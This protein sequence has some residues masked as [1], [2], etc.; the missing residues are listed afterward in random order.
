[1]SG[2][3][4]I[5]SGSHSELPLIHAARRL[6]F[7][8]TT[9]GNR[10]DHPGH[11]ISDAYLP[12]DFSCPIQMLEVAKNSGCDFIVS[13]AN[14][15]A[16][17]SSCEVA[18]TLGYTGF[19]QPTVAYSLHHKHL[20]KPL[21]ASL[22]IP[23]TKFVSIGQ[24][25]L[26]IRC[27]EGLAFPL[28]VKP[29]DLTGGKGITVVND[30]ASLIT[31][32]A[33]ARSLSKSPYVVIE[34]YFDGTLHS[35]STIIRHGKVIFEYSD[36]EFCSPS[37]YLVSTSTSQAK[38]TQEVLAE[39]KIHTEKLAVKLGLIDG[40]LHCQ[41]LYQNR[42]FVIL[43]YTRRCSGDLYSEVVEAVTGIRH[44]E[45]FIRQSTGLPFDLTRTSPVSQFISRHCVFPKQDGRFAGICIES[46][47]KKH[48]HSITEAFPHGYAVNTS[49]Q[50]KTAVVI[51][52]FN[53]YQSMEAFRPRFHELINCRLTSP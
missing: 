32:V 27:I 44:A 47:L 11:K 36:N 37:P 50:E 39:L 41:F 53:D 49:R 19:D 26:D 16:Y 15:Y 45:Q 28:V 25:P 5:F 48:I 10:P 35:Y 29:I 46:E 18:A 31:A 7:R 9:S 8:V 23:V 3:V 52:K 33:Y 40:I 20:F 34:E 30:E 43:E 14:D 51:T 22:G 17:L 24:G 42:N 38:V 2:H 1:M 12:A 6:G 13:A 21:A 4:L